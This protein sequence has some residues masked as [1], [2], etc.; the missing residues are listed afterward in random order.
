LSSVLL[1]YFL[2]G[3]VLWGG[4]VIGY[5]E[6]GVT[7]MV[8]S[9]VSG[10]GVTLNTETANDVENLNG[11]IEQAVNTFAGGGLLAAWKFVSGL[12]DFMFWPTS[13]PISTNAPVEVTV[14][15]AT[16]NFSFVLGMVA[17]FRRGF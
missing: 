17:I 4:G 1:V 7:E 9:G 6:A 13:V 14:G 5:D 10:Q 15:M 8:I 11:P 3:F 16:L 2:I 12:I